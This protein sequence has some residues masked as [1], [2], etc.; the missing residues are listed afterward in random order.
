MQQLDT[1]AGEQALGRNQTI[2]GKLQ[3]TVQSATQQAKAIDQQKGYSKVANDVSGGNVGINLVLIQSA[4]YYSR[5]LSSPWGQKVKAFYTTTTK[6]VQDIHE[7]AR[8]IADQR[9]QTKAP[10]EPQDA[11]GSAA[12]PDPTIQEKPTAV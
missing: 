8:R 10:A 11:P 3:A 6:Q 12:V 7:E 4:K 2:S 9:K 1:K 5:A